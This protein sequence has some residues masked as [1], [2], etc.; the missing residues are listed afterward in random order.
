M[1]DDSAQPEE[2]L[3]EFRSGA[4]LGVHHA[5]N[6]PGSAVEV[7]TQRQTLHSNPQDIVLQ[8]FAPESD[9]QFI[10]LPQGE[11]CVRLHVVAVVISAPL[12]YTALPISATPQN[13]SQARDFYQQQ[14]AGDGSRAGRGS[15]AAVRSTVLRR[16]TSFL[17]PTEI[18]RPIGHVRRD[19]RQPP[20]LFWKPPI[21]LRHPG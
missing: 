2:K 17:S 8:L 1:R 7:L 10:A 12:S 3:A 4:V 5:F 9:L 11:V 21:V 13:S 15:T 19:S 20:F 14:R 18:R 6:G 16:R